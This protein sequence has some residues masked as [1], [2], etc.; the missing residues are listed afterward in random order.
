MLGGLMRGVYQAG[1]AA[2]TVVVLLLLS[3]VVQRARHHSVRGD[4]DA[5]NL[6]RALEQVGRVLGLFLVV[7]A[8]VGGGADGADW[9]SDV[10]WSLAFGAVAV[11]LLEAGG[12]LG[13]KMLLQARLPAEIERGNAAAGLAAGAHYAATGVVIAHN[14]HGS[15]LGTLAVSLVFF[16]LAQ[17]SLHVFVVLFRALT[18]YDDSEEVLTGNLAAALSY[19]GI[20]LAVSIVVGAASDGAFAGW[21]E[22]LK[23]YG[24]AVLV[25]LVFYPVRQLI[26]QGLLLGARPTLRAGRLDE[27]V[28]IER[29]VGF[30]ALE[31]VS[32][33]ATAL[34]LTRVM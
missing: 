14:I 33:V 30:G 1:L 6:A 10:L 9:R 4:L 8:V 17:L 23:G 3:Q 2:A 27:A 32:Y 31:A 13:V 21:V 11:G 28:G 25:S 19:A 29:N 20:T 16:V 22:S 18:A 15:G 24:L 34:L 7:G 26:V 12:A 5:G